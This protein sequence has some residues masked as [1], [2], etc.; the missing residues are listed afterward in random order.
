MIL[1]IIL[2]VLT[3]GFLWIFQTS[4]LIN[5]DNKFEQLWG[6]QPVPIKPIG[7]VSQIASLET[8]VGQGCNMNIDRQANINS[9]P[10]AARLLWQHWLQGL[11][12]AAEELLQQTDGQT[13]YGGL[14]PKVPRLHCRTVDG[15]QY[16]LT[17]SSR[18]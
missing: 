2:Q 9:H 6:D 12:A 11:P 3:V 8:W 15:L 4:L 17:G 1:L 13:E 5:V 18:C 14:S 7:N 16:I 10:T